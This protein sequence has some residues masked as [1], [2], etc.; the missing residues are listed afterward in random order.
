MVDLIAPVG[1][2]AGD[3]NV[4][5]GYACTAFIFSDRGGHSAY[6]R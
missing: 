6:R 5:C 2:G 3:L 1:S 4:I